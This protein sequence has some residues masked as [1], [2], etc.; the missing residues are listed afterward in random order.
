MQRYIKITMVLMVGLFGL[1]GAFLN[2][3]GAHFEIVEI[4]KV[5]TGAGAKGVQEWQK[6]ENPI[7]VW[8]AW[9]VIPFCKFVAGVL[10]LMGVKTM[11]QFRKADRVSFQQAKRFAMTGCGLLLAMLFGV[12]ILVT[13]TWFQQ[14]QT[15]FGS[16]VLLTAHRY[17]LSVGILMIYIQ[18]GDDQLGTES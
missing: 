5:V 8:I 9:S 1:Y 6:I 18:M 3:M 14:W 16:G 12:F 13:E 2:V 10:C 15:E 17:L 7:L 4:S 11:W